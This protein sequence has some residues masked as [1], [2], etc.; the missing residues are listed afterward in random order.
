MPKKIITLVLTAVLQYAVFAQN[1]F[2]SML[3][4]DTVYRFNTSVKQL[5]S[6]FTKNPAL[7]L[8]KDT[9]FYNSFGSA[10]VIDLEL[11]IFFALDRSPE[12]K[13][14]KQKINSETMLAGERGYLP[15]PML[16]VEVDDIMSD[17]KRAG[18]INFF[19]S[20]MFMFPGKLSLESDMALNGR[21]MLVQEYRDMEL[22]MINMVKMKLF[23]LYLVKQ[24][25]DVN[26]S[27]QLI[28]K[29]FLAAAEARYSVGR[30]MQMEVFKSQIE[31]S[32]LIN[33][34]AVF[35]RE[36][37][38]ILSELT[39]LTKVVIDEKTKI[40]FGSIDA[41]YILNEDSFKPEEIN[42]DRLVTYALKNRADLKAL[43]NRVIMNK[44]DLDISR[45]SRMPDFS[46]RLGYKVLPFEERNAFSVMVGVSIPIAPWTSGKY[47]YREQKSLLKVRS[48]NEEYE[49]LR[50]RIR[51]EVHSTVNTLVS[52]RET[53]KY[54]YTV[55]VPQS[56]SSL[57]ASQYSYE[58]NLS[59]FLDLLDSYRMYQEAR[60]MLYE[61]MNMYL[62][63]IA[64]LEYVTAMNLKKGN[65]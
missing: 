45:I 23:D 42:K 8:T 1:S 52:A 27:D 53:M 47:G 7:E 13:A 14:L 49:D 28:M 31:L 5:D 21:D 57:K 30:G 25:L 22:K 18:M 41:D 63:M 15:D 50:N 54:Y 55:V 10:E 9:S 36:R 12:L 43:E 65:N 3:E 26:A 62:K 60:F 4:K 48:V 38:N 2:N 44:T 20:Q 6:L 16:E 39:K 33:D 34:E 32:R 58:N 56:E 29:T 35:E 17:F 64:E 37:R 19:A 11:L 51:N 24:K 61:S 46:L 40:N 59:S